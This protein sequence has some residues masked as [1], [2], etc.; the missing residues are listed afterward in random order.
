MAKTK[1]SPAE[2]TFNWEAMKEELLSLKSIYCGKG[3]CEVVSPSNLSF[4]NL[5][6]IEPDISEGIIIQILVYPSIE[7]V[8]TQKLCLSVL[9]HLGSTYPQDA[10]TITQISSKHFSKHVTDS[11][12]ERLNIFV[13]TLQPEPR[14]FETLEH[15]KEDVLEL[16]ARDP[17]VLHNTGLADKEETFLDS[18]TTPSDLSNMAMVDQTGKCGHTSKHPCAKQTPMGGHPTAHVCIAKLDHMRNE[19]RYLKVL[20]SWAKE[21]TIHGKIF[22]TGL[23]SIYVIIVGMSAASVNEFLKRWRTQS[24]DVD[25]Q[26]RPCKEKLLS[27]LCQQPLSDFVCSWSGPTG[28]YAYHR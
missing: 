9:I 1:F 3:E 22:H 17:S 15:L 13:K 5:D 16:V 18:H 12:H 19:Q 11:I 25:S 26:R 21:L 24:V 4:E 14:L 10:P 2:K 7:Q 27:V 20:N 28:R 23:R 8:A 6:H